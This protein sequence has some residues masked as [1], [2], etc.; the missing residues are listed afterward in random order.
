MNIVPVY[1]NEQDRSNTQYEY[2][3]LDKLPEVNVDDICR[4]ASE[5]CH[6]PMSLVCIIDAQKQW[7][8]PFS[9]TGSMDIPDGFPFCSNEEIFI[10]QDLS[11]DKD[12]NNH[13][14][15]AGKLNAAFY[16]GVRLM[17]SEGKTVGTLCVLDTTPRQLK[18]LQV[19][20]LQSL[21]RQVSSLLELSL[22]PASLKRNRPNWP[23]LMLILGR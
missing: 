17:N 6:T 23:W 14:L 21:G 5:I 7:I 16:V 2:N 22:K 3:N 13:A 19:E 18:T 9:L 10:I 15:V 11:A 12:Y 8:K 1:K 20:A 4:I